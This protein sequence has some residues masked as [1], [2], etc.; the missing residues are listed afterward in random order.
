[1]AYRQFRL[2]YLHRYQ[3]IRYST[4][5]NTKYLEPFHV[6]DLNFRF[7]LPVSGILPM[8]QAQMGFRMENVWN[9]EYEIMHRMPEPG[10]HWRTNL[11]IQFT[12]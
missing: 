6:A 10:R 12:P 11:T 2:E 4:R 5:S 9:T 8:L 3:G 7:D 1:M